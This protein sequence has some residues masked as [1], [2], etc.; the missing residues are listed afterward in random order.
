MLFVAAALRRK[1]EV[2]PPTFQHRLEVAGIRVMGMLEL[3]RTS[4]LCRVHRCVYKRKVDYFSTVTL[5]DCMK[6]GSKC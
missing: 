6:H 3:T 2:Q 4:F 5:S 1:F